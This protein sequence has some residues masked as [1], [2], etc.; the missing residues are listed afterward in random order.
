MKKATIDIHQKF[1]SLL[2]QFI[3][4]AQRATASIE[5]IKND[6]DS[7]KEAI[8]NHIENEEKVILSEPDELP[9]FLFEPI[10]KLKNVITHPSEQHLASTKIGISDTFAGVARTGSIC[11]SI[12]KNLCGSVSLYT[13]E[14]IA[15][16]D[17]NL[18]VARPRDIFSDD[19]LDG[20]YINKNFVFITGTSA[21][22][23]MGPLVRGVHGPGKLHIIILE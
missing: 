2:D 23:D 21:T 18:I 3:F 15:I 9:E 8:L 6:P 13:R 5:R 22:A 17:S 12:S 4:T 16:L 19:F 1:P 7:L 11:V 10:K 20:K 14:H